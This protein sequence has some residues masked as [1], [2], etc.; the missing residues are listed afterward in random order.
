MHRILICDDHEIVRQGLAESITAVDGWEIVGEA[1]NGL[2]AISRAKELKPDLIILDSAM[3]FARGIEVFSEVK[4]WQPKVKVA[5]LTGFTSARLLA[6]WLDSGIDGLF[7]KS[8]P[9]TEITEGIT[10][11]L[12]GGKFISEQAAEIVAKAGASPSLT[13]REHEVLNLICAGNSNIAIAERLGISSKT[14][15]KHRGSL[16]N[17]LDVHSVSDLMTFALREGLLDEHRQL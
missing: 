17:K 12:A 3:P 11:I 13:A 10:T 4:R 5:V 7:L 6:D 1:A 14:V 15:E 8:G 16:M 2:E 9:S